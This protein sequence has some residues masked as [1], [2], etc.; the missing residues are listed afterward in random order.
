MNIEIIKLI[1][2]HAEFT[3]FAKESRRV[4]PACHTYGRS[5]K[6]MT[7]GRASR[8]PETSSG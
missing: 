2:C 7:V 5:V 1:N 6:G 3:R 4:S 8:D